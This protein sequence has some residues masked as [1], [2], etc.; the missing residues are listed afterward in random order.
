VAQFVAERKERDGG[1]AGAPLSM[2]FVQTAASFLENHH[3]LALL[4]IVFLFSSIIFLNI[5]EK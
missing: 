1:Q 5:L 3:K 4:K 2:L